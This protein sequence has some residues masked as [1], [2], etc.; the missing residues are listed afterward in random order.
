MKAMNAMRN[1]A[2]CG[3]LFCL[4]GANTATAGNAGKD[5]T[6]LL[7]YFTTCL[8]SAGEAPAFA[9]GKRLS[10]SKTDEYRQR[11][12]EAWKTANSRLDEEKLSPLQPLS[13]KTNAQWNLP[14][15]LEP[16]A[17]MPYYWGSKGTAKPDEGYPLFLYT[18]GSGPKAAEWATGLQICQMFD[19]APSAYFIPQIPNEGEYYRWW[20]KSKQFAW[21]KLLRQAL[22]SGDINPDR[23]YIF[24]ISEGGYGSQRLASFY[25]DYL[26][27]AGPMAGGEPLKNAPAE[28][29]ANIA[30]SLLTGAVDRGFYR[31]MLTGYVKAEFERLQKEHPGLFTHR[32]ELIPNRGHSIDYRPTT[33]WL[34]QYTRN[35]YPKYV[36]WEDFE[37]D[38]LHRKGFY[39]LVVKER[40][41]ADARTRYE[42]TIEGNHI[43]LNVDDVTYETIQKDPHWGIELKFKK[44]YTPAA[45]GKVLL[46]LNSELVDLKQ[47][48]TV[49]VN[50]K[51]VFEGKVKPDLKHLVNSCATFFDPQRIYPAAVEVAW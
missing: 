5:N 43:A 25:A 9:Q 15:E 10:L 21:E 33:P 37:M 36:L 12:W 28:N 1:A 46:Y 29:C 17:V 41:S 14:S 11:V 3:V 38:G 16:K 44:S 39:N 40:P 48:V 7:N 30:F 23:V 49:T 22:A 50:G 32:I 34:K 26:A 24:G 31:N 4:A 35:P 8:T 27:G 6:A 42:M 2:L 45:K 13:D 51:Q 18:H 20:Q 19:D 47:K